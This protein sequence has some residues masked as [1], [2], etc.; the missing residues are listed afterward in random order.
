MARRTRQRIAVPVEFDRWIHGLEN[1]DPSDE[2]AAAWDDAMQVFYGQS[3]ESVHVISNALRTTGRYEVTQEAGDRV[4]GDL[5]YGGQTV[6]VSAHGRTRTVDYA[7][8][9][10]NRGGDHAWMTVAFAQSR[11]RFE[12]ALRDGIDAHVRKFL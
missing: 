7:I 2:V 6:K 12:Q 5:I 3:Q 11:A 9:E 10:H 8:Y 4:H 1:F